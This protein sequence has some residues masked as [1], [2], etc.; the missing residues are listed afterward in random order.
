MPCDYDPSDNPFQ[1]FKQ[2]AD[3]ATYM[4]DYDDL[5]KDVAAGNL[6]EVSFVKAV[7]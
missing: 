2:F 6:P 7:Q 1:Y 4:K 5:A 3:N